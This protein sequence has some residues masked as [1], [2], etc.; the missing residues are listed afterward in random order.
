MH[1]QKLSLP[2]DPSTLKSWLTAIRKRWPDTKLITQGEFGLLWRA[3]YKSNNFNYRFVERGSGVGG[4]DANNE[5][6]WFM[7]KDFR[8]A[9]L[10]DWKTNTPE[11]VID[12]TR[13]D[14]PTKEPAEL[15]RK[16]SLLGEIN[17]KQSRAQDKPVPLDSLSKIDKV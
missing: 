6:S 7:N 8:L 16:W 11:K 3:H 15:T 1:L 17:Q 5:I 14:I 10:K 12:F 9:L 13:Y 4:S 2:Y